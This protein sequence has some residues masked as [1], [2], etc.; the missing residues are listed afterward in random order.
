MSLQSSRCSY[1][2]SNN[3]HKIDNIPDSELTYFCEMYSIKAENLITSSLFYFKYIVVYRHRMI[4]TVSCLNTSGPDCIAILSGCIVDM[5]SLE[6][7]I[8][9]LMHRETFIEV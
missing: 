8:H 7:L 5:P 9:V 4:K 3:W 2:S 6:S 1:S